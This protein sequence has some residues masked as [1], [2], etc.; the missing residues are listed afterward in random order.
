MVINKVVIKAEC[1]KFVDFWDVIRDSIFW[2]LVMLMNALSPV[3]GCHN[4]L[5]DPGFLTA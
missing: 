4:I 1:W 3:G 5:A 2:V